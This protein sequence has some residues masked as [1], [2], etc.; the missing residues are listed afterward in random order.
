[1]E[2]L[3]SGCFCCCGGGGGGGGGSSDTGLPPRFLR[4][5]S[6]VERGGRS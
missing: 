2:V 6:S 4:D 5:W 3:G 1:V